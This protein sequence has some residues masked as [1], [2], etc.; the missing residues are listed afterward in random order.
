MAGPQDGLLQLPYYAP[1][2]PFELPTEEDIA[3]PDEVLSELGGRKVVRVG[4]KFTIKYGH[5]DAGNL[6]EPKRTLKNF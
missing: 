3:S 5:A 6:F 2:T 4:Q 1:N